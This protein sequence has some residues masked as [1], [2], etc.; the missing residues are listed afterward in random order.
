MTEGEVVEKNTYAHEEEETGPRAEAN[1]LGSE[2]EEMPDC[3]SPGWAAVRV[4]V[5][6]NAHQSELNFTGG[7]PG[8]RDLAEESGGRHT[9]G[10]VPKVR[11]VERIKEL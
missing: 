10:R 1:P 5:L 7:V 2:Q 3:G 6:P 11:V 8:A 9:R 4:K